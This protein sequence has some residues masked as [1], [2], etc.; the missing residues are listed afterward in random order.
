MTELIAGL[1]QVATDKHLDAYTYSSI[2][3]L[4]RKANEALISGREFV[5][6]EVDGIMS[7]QVI[8][9]PEKEVYERGKADGIE[10][11]IMQGREDGETLLGSLI[12]QLLAAGRTDDVNRACD[13]EK[14]RAQ[15]Y[16]EFGL[17]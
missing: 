7:T 12:K 6:K 10:Q 13:D 1:N 9:F 15:L 17:A 4:M 8:T 16:K 11:G 5:K 3:Q 2:I 14:T